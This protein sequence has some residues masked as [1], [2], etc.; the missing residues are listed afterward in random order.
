MCFPAIDGYRGNSC[1]IFK[2]INTIAREHIP[3]SIKLN[4]VF[5]LYQLDSRQTSPAIFRPLKLVN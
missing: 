3:E 5:A 4:N 2:M 1:E